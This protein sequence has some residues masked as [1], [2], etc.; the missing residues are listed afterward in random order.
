MN[1]ISWFTRIDKKKE[2]ADIPRIGQA[3]NL[4]KDIIIIQ[5]KDQIQEKEKD[6]ERIVSTDKTNKKLIIIIT[7]HQ[8]KDTKSMKEVAIVKKEANQGIQFVLSHSDSDS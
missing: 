2:E 8:I 3:A 7:N 6:Q 4:K 1:I 5:E